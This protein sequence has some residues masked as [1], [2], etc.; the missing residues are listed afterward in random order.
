MFSHVMPCADD[1]EVF[2]KFDDALLGTLAIKR[3]FANSKRYFYR[4]LTAAFAL[5]LPINGALADQ[6]LVANTTAWPA[7]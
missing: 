5:Y 2:K 3:W 1:G 4:G 6:S 7:F